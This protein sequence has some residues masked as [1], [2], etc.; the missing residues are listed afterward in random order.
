MER[1]QQISR[2]QQL[3]DELIAAYTAEPCDRPTIERLTDELAALQRL[4][5]HPAPPAAPPS[6][7]DDEASVDVL[8]D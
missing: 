7:P 3:E 1:S 2:Y 6:P 4:L 5:R 8:L